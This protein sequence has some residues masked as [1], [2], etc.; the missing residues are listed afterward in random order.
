VRGHIHKE[1]YKQ[2]D[3]FDSKSNSRETAVASFLKSLELDQSKEFEEWNS[4]SLKYLAST[5]WNDAVNTIENADSDGIVEAEG[6]YKNYVKTLDAFSYEYDKNKAALDFYKAYATANRKMIEQKRHMGANPE[7]YAEELLRIE[8]SYL[9]ALE[10]NSEDYGSNYNYSINL[11][12]EAAYRI[13]RIPAEADLT[14]LLLEQAG[15]IEIFKK[16]LPYANKAYDQRP[17]RIE[18]LKALRAIHLSLSDYEQFER[19]DMLIKEKQGQMSAPSDP[20]LDRSIFGKQKL[21]K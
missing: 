20:K 18:I 10:K 12:N 17:G 9:E 14:V 8:K 3:K 15:C 16:A 13:E 4:T 11:Y 19:Y 1:V 7:S 21:D 2:V 5:F 6:A